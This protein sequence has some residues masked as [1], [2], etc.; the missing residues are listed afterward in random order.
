MLQGGEERVQLRQRRPLCRFQRL[1][2]RH[3]PA[4]FAL[5]RDGG[6][7]EL[8]CAECLVAKMALDSLLHLALEM[9]LEKVR[10]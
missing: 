10:S 3:S 9:S 1:H 2:R 8:L 4:E 6:K 5:Q 7:W